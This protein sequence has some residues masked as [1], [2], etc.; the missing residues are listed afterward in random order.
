MK[1]ARIVLELNADRMSLDV[2]MGF[3]STPI[4][5]GKSYYISI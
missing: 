2:L 5:D 1:R 3:V 4:T